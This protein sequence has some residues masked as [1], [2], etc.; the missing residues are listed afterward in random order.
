MQEFGKKFNVLLKTKN[1]SLNLNKWMDDALRI[2][3]LIF[4]RAFDKFEWEEK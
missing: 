4:H 1:A 3:L 2:D